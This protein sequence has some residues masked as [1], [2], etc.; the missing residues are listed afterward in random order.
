MATKYVVDTHALVWFLEGNPRLGEN[1]KAVLEDLNSKLVLPVVVLAEAC[2]MIEHGKTSIPTVNDFLRAV[3]TDPRV[4]VVPLDRA[5]L[6]KTLTLAAI[7]ELHD[8]QIVATALL[9]GEQGE[10]V[11]LVTKDANIRGSG[12]VST[13]W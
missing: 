4:I 1:A 3:D 8:R 6:D 10:P 13:I 5:V 9:L 11:A 7:P 12:F 2:W